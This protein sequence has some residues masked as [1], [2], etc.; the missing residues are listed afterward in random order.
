MRIQSTT[1]PDKAI[2]F[3]EWRNQFAQQ[4]GHRMM[5][6]IGPVTEAEWNETREDKR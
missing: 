2:P 4:M 6:T 3:A 1:Y 5:H